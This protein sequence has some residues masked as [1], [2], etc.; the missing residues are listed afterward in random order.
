MG[1]TVWQAVERRDFRFV[2]C[3]DHVERW[4]TKECAATSRLSR[5]LLLKGAEF[6]QPVRL[7]R[8]SWLPVCVVC[9]FCDY[10]CSGL[11]WLGLGIHGQVGHPIAIW[12][13][14][15]ISTR[16]IGLHAGV[17]ISNEDC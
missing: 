12:R 10:T 4:K 3:S 7:Q 14:Q 1:E 11:V 9:L 5:S 6:Q 13:Y 17:H 2:Q 8:I 16:E 15:L